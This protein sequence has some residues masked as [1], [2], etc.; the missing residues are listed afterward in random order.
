MRG[1]NSRVRLD[2]D[3]TVG[4]WLRFRET[5]PEAAAVLL[6]DASRRAVRR[7]KGQPAD[8]E[9]WAQEAVL[10]ALADDAA[11]LRRADPRAPLLGWLRV[12]HRNV[13]RE[14]ARTADR[15]PLADP[16]ASLVQGGGGVEIE[17]VPSRAPSPLEILAEEDESRQMVASVLAGARQL[18]KPYGN[19]LY[20]SVVRGQPW[21]EVRASLNAHRP[22]ASRPIEGRQ[23]RY[24]I[25]DAI[26]MFG[27]HRAGADL[28]VLHRQKYLRAKNPWIGAT[29]PPLSAQIPMEG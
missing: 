2:T 10:R 8:R 17:E 12:C 11:A 7:G 27:E 16:P 26:G 22:P 3:P 21:Q 15:L 5:A 23:A 13:R 6:L 29:L 28:R 9:D 25:H 20:L 1:F 24:L 4:E 14:A 19:A 18:P